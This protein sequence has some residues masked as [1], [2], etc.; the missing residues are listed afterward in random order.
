MLLKN[1]GSL[2]EVSCLFDETNVM[3]SDFFKAL[4]HPIR[5]KILELLREGERCVCEIVPGP[6]IEQ[7]N[8]SRHLNVLKKE[9]ILSSRKD[10]LKVIYKVNDPQIYQLLDICK[11]IIKS[12]WE[13]KGSMIM[14]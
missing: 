14:R 10:G 13:K 4:G 8:I 11:N 12:H 9:G 5:I 6:E 3:Q 7:P 1:G 2:K